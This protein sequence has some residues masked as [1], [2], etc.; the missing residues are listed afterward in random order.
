MDYMYCEECESIFPEDHA[1]TLLSERGNMILAC[2]ECR[3]T[4]LQVA[5]KCGFCGE[6]IEPSKEYCD[7]CKAKAHKIWEEAVSKIID[8]SDI[9]MDYCDCEH[10]FI[11]FLENEGVF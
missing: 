6:P 5:G 4:W 10:E 7:D 3:N 1:R 8:I 2:P 9:D 11:D